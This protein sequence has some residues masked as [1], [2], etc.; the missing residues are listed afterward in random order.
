MDVVHPVTRKPVGTRIWFRSADSEAAREF[1]R[2]QEQAALVKPRMAAEAEESHADLVERRICK[3]LAALVVRVEEFEWKGAPVH[4]ADKETLEEVFFRLSWLREQALAFV[5]DVANYLGK[6]QPSSSP[7]PAASS[8][9]EN[10]T[11]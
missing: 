4:A 6:S 3:L 10:V 7:S 2:A 8:S 11:G 5:N 9:S 1:R